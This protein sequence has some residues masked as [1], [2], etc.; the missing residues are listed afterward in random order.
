M[1][2]VPNSHLDLLDDA[3]RAYAYLGTVMGDG[4]PQVTPIWFN[5]DGDHVLIN[6]ARGRVKD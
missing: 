4:S 5:I 6:S 1:M 2:N 3:T